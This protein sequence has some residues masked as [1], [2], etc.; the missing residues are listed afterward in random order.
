MPH[1]TKPARVVFLL[2]DL[3]FGG[4]QRQALEL[5]LRLDRTR[6]SPEFWMLADVRDFAP[7]AEAGGIPLTWLSPY[8]TV[9]LGSLLALRRALKEHRPDL[10]VPLTAMPNIWGRVFAKT[11]GLSAVI[12]TCRGGGAIK[13]QHERFLKGLCA[14]HIVNAAPLARE[15]TA[16]GRPAAKIT[17]IPN[18]VDTGHFLPPPDDLRP[19][20]EVVLCL[21]RFCEDKDHETLIRSFEY[22]AAKRPRAELWLVGDGP[23]RTRVRTLATRSPVR[24]LIRTYPST[25]DP[26]P[27]FQQASVVVLSSVREGLPNVLLEAMAMGLPVAATAVGGIP[28]L[29]VP[30]TTGL[31]CPPRNPEALGENIASLLADEDRRLA[32]GK[33]ARTRAET[34]YSMEA[35]VLRHE[36]V[37]AR[38]LSGAPAPDEPGAQP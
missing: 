27:F 38:V 30:E 19:V 26:R 8:P 1:A 7:R 10:L 28:D 15:L 18:G 5:G 17:C 12:G 16:M 34:L 24:G 3:A 31:L 14:H 6:F 11:Q 4:T 32:M 22:V 20:R 36:A 2:Q 9:G 37:F 35:M 23:L 13:R 25:P 29:V 21:A 33:N